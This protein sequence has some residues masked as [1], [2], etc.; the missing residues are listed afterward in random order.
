VTHSKAKRFLSSMFHTCTRTSRRPPS[1]TSDLRHL[2]TEQPEQTN[3]G[4]PKPLSAKICKWSEGS[5]T[6]V[7]FSIIN[8]IKKVMCCMCALQ[9]MIQS[10]YEVKRVSAKQVRFPELKI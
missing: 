8:L 4:F 1:L 3:L 5:K 7:P 6:L 2:Q 10:M 9:I